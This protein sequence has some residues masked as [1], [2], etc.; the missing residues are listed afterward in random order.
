[1]K[2]TICIVLGALVGG[3]VQSPAAWGQTGLEVGG[4]PAIN[5]DADEGFG[6]GAIVEIYQYGDGVQQPYRWTLQPKVF[7][8]TEGRRDFTVFF[9]AP[10][11]LGAWRL[12]AFVGSEKQLATPYYGMGNDAAFDAGL[13]TG[14]DPYYYRFGRTR[15]GASLNVQ[16]PLGETP[17]RLLIGVGAV[18]GSVDISPFDEGGTFL[19][20][21]LA[22][23]GGFIEDGWSDYVRAGL[24][25]DTR[26]RET[27]PRRGTWTEFLVQRV[28]EAL[29]ST[30]SY[31]RLSFT[32]RRY[33]SL[34][35][36]VLAH[37]LF[38]QQVSDDVAFHEI[39]RV[40]ASFKGQEGI[41]GAQTVRGVLKNRYIGRGLMVW[42]TEL[43]YRALE[44]DA[45]GKPF[46]VV[47]SGYADAGRVWKDDM[48]LDELFSDLHR[49][50]GGGLRIGM[51]ENFTVAFDAGTS[52]ETG[53]QVYIGLGYLY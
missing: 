2:R 52:E 23:T 4:V 7:L 30:S 17:L 15:R 24:I 19:A 45:L 29:G 10:R 31:T 37:R 51:G 27:G 50:Y 9:D 26:D 34:G 33:F 16:R 5:F 1:M 35:P 53:V 48:H 20:Q 12:D 28:D 44:F 6:Y 11:F 14:S 32:D 41:G 46:H 40:Q 8:T 43:R 42:N 38:V 22:N 18:H 13:V 21:E 36:V 47:L 3:A 25:Y 49:G 39:H